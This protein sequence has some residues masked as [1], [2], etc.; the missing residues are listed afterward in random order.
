MYCNV[1]VFGELDEA[2]VESVGAFF[3]MIPFPPWEQYG[4]PIIII[5]AFQLKWNTAKQA[6]V[7]P[8]PM[9]IL[10]TRGKMY[11]HRR[12]ASRFLGARARGARRIGRTPCSSAPSSSSSPSAPGHHSTARPE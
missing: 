5:N 6:P 11:S 4:T 12:A 7:L 2:D 8:A 9:P 1:R 10:F 3:D